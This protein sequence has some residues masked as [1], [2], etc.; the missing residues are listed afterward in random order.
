MVLGLFLLELFEK[1]LYLKGI[2]MRYRCYIEFD[3]VELV[4][5]NP[6]VRIKSVNPRQILG[7]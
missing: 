3:Q 2:V 1:N 6:V 7:K 4:Q 5:M